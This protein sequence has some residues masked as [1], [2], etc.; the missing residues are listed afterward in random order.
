MCHHTSFTRG[1]PG[2]AITVGSS[3]LDMVRLMPIDVPAHNHAC[4]QP[5][6]LCMEA[7]DQQGTVHDDSSTPSRVHER[8][9]SDLMAGLSEQLQEFDSFSLP[10]GLYAPEAPS[11]LGVQA[12]HRAQP[13][14]QLGLVNSWPFSGPITDSGGNCEA[15]C[16]S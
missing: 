11:T 10:P 16:L 4:S 14:V 13:A 1:H 9:P 5:Q 15:I 8:S 7:G 2:F 6:G 3:P 12:T